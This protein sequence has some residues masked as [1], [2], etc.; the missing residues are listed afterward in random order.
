LEYKEEYEV[1]LSWV[2]SVGKLNMIT[3]TSIGKRYR[4]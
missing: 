4:Y 1:Q 2:C 3:R